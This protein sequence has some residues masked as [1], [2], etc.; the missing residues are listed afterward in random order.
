M[1]FHVIVFLVHLTF[2]NILLSHQFY[3]CLGAQKNFL[4]E[5]ILLSTNNATTYVLVEKYE[6]YFFLLRTLKYLHFYT[7]KVVPLPEG[8]SRQIKG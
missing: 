5:T 1:I 4:I 7:I 8:Y 6:T 2:V 3:I